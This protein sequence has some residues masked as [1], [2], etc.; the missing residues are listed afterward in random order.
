MTFGY[1]FEH[2]LLNSL[3]NLINLTH[4][5]FGCRFNCPLENSLENLNN[6]TH[7]T[8]GNNFN[9]SLKN[10]MCYRHQIIKWDFFL[11]YVKLSW[12]QI[13]ILL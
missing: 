8:F 6:L 12:Q 7:L 4:L 9:Q 13:I 11:F 3:D 10:S 5:T 1:C 2:S